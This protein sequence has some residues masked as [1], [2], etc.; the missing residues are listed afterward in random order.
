MKNENLP[1]PAD[2]A[3]DRERH[4]LH[5]E[6]RSGG[7]SVYPLDAL[8]EACPCAV[9]RGGHDKM[10]PEHDPDFIELKPA[11]SFQVENISLVGNY[12][13]N[14]VWSDGHTAGIYTWDYLYR[15]NP[16]TRIDKS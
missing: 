2:I 13:L 10:G 7:K 12:A 16:P 4:E 14:F 1:R 3:L 15:I 8:R 5:I 6:W 9:C 11:R